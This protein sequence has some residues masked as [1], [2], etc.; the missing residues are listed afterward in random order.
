MADMGWDKYISDV[1]K[2]AVGPCQDLLAHYG[3]D[4]T[5]PLDFECHERGSDCPI[6]D[7]CGMLADL[8]LDE[9]GQPDLPCS[10]DVKP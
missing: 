3:Y 6:R 8:V 7:K 5:D 1:E 2:V 10:C 9:G 4:D